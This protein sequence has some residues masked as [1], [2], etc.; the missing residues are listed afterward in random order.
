VLDYQPAV[1]GL[2]PNAAELL[3]RL[4]S[5]LA[6]GRQS[7]MYVGYVW[8]A[9]DDAGYDDVPTTNKQ[10]RPLADARLF[11][12]GTPDATVH[13]TVA[14]HDEDIVARKTRVGA[15][16]T[17]DIDKQFRQRG[18]TTLILAGLTTSGA[19][20]STVRDAADHDYE[21]LV[22]ADASADPD[23]DLH[24]LLIER[25][26]PTQAHVITTEPLPT[27]IPTA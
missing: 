8:V 23:A 25:V 26:F 4:G 20:L 17:T 6:L 2:F 1:L 22:L 24:E 21:I 13:E 9:F 16:S 10:F 11:G 15:F 12:D 27:L 14:P 3:N 5:A 18:I 19:V 7:G